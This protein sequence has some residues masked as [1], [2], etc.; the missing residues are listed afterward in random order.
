MRRILAALDFSADSDRVLKRAAELAARRGAELT[1]AHVLV[2]EEAPDPE[3]SARALR[4]LRDYAGAGLAAAGVS[5]RTD[6]R[7][8][9]GDPARELAA[10]VRETGADLAVLGAHRDEPIRDLFFEAT[11]YYTI[12]QCSA[13]FLV[14]REPV[15]G[16]YQKALALTDFSPCSKRA[17]HAAVTVAPEAEFHLLHVY[18]TPFPSF[19]RFTDDELKDYR[20]ERVAQI[21]RDVE[22]EMLHFIARHPDDRAPS[23]TPLLERNDVDAGIAAAVR[24]LQPDLLAM[25]MSG[26][27]WASLVGSRTTAYLDRPICDMIVA[28]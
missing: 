27:G 6:F 12:R 19:V 3:T 2:G 8:A 13:P 24:R 10:L 14:V 28:L 17:L 26:R 20:R 1:L 7:I 21:E 9:A 15:R 25:G 22:E 4:R 5:A 16:P 11:A 18:Q 23:I